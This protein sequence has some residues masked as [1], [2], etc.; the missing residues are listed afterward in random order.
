MQVNDAIA[1][2]L[3]GAGIALTLIGILGMW[4]ETRE[5]LRADL[6]ALADAL[7]VSIVALDD[8]LNIHASDHCDE[9]RVAEARTR[10]NERGTI[11]YISVVQKTNRDALA[12]LGKGGSE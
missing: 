8:W 12:R 2:M 1:L 5:K 7:R 9:R 11:Y 4:T 6:T 10:I 3:I